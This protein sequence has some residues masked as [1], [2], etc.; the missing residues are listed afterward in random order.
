MGGIK[1]W[2]LLVGSLV[3][4]ALYLE[5][6][7]LSRAID[8]QQRI[9]LEAQ[10][11]AS[12]GPTYE[13]S[14]KQLATRVYQMSR[15]DKALVEVLKRNQIAVQVNPPVSP[16]GSSPQPAPLSSKVKAPVGP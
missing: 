8:Q 7:Y 9:L 16:D 15:N 2:I 12:L 11:F 3:V 5:Q 14:W 4:C 10:Q 6:I 13:N 1:F